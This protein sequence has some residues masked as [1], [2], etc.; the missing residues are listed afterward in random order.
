M[1]REFTSDWVTWHTDAWR[2]L[3]GP[4]AGKPHL[5][6]LEVGTYEGRSALWWLDNILT[7]RTSVLYVVD[8][9]RN[10]PDREVRCRANLREFAASGRVTIRK[11]PSREILP[12]FPEGSFDFVYIDGSHEAADVLL[13]GLL[14]LPLVKRGGLLL[15]DDYEWT[16][17]ARHHSPKPGVDAFLAVC[18]WQVEL[19]SRSYQVAV[20][21]RRV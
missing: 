10:C 12:G 17:P 5:R 20:R 7:H 16:G 15:F 4:L 18:D 3:L 21:K 19:V 13:D 6:F 8:P 1:S 11:G 9:W 2:R 14:C